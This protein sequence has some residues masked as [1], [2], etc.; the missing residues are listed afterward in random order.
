MKKLL[1]LIL[2]ASAGL[3]AQSQ[4][5]C[6]G[7]ICVPTSCQDAGS[8]DAYACNLSPAIANYETG[9]TY[10]FKANTINTGPASINFNSLGAVTIV[11]VAG[12]IST[13]LVDGDILAGQW[14]TMIYDGTNME[15]QASGNALG[16]TIINSTTLC[17]NGCVMNINGNGAIHATHLKQNIAQSTI[18]ITIDGGGS[19]I[20]TGVKGYVRAPYDCS[21]AAGTWTITQDQSGS[22]VI[23]V[24][25]RTFSTTLLPTVANTITASA[26]PTVSSTVNATGST[27]TW[28]SAV[29]AGDVFGF[30]VD[31]ATTVTRV[32]LELSCPI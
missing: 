26:K 31:S 24:W 13:A 16:G 11:K 3:H 12:T 2:I 21:F 32:T 28:T 4:R 10:R 9:M 23:D 14:V 6:V 18:G 29:T 20:T 17:G 8:S 19:A 5:I 25:K 22:I 30:N 1:A 7:S 15:L 27:S